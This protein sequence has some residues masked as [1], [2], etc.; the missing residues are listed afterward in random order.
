[1]KPLTLIFTFLATIVFCLCNKGSTNGTDK[2]PAAPFPPFNSTTFNKTKLHIG[3][4]LPF[5][6]THDKMM[7]HA[8]M[9]TA[10]RLIN[11][12]SNILKDYELVLDFKE[13]TVMIES[14]CFF[15]FFFYLFFFFFLFLILVISLSWTLGLYFCPKVWNFKTNLRKTPLKNWGKKIHNNFKI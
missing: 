5:L 7:F 8:A 10:M 15:M 12:D 9:Y 11:N 1:M 3:A 13:T 6:L 2:V 14:V 4:L